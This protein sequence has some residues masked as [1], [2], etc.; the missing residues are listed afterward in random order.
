MKTKLTS[1]TVAVLLMSLLIA[2]CAPVA[3]TEAPPM[4]ETE[5]PM[6]EETEAPESL[7]VPVKPA[8]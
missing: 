7:P 6:P 5:A 4:E 2:S 8:P 1:L 3:T